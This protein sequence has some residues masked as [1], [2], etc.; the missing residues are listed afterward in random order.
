MFSFLGLCKNLLYAMFCKKYVIHLSGNLEYHFR[1]HNPIYNYLTIKLLIKSAGIVCL[2]KSSLQIALKYNNNSV[3]I[4]NFICN[5]KMQEISMIPKELHKKVYDFSYHGRITQD[6]GM[7]ELVKLVKNLH[8]YTFLIIGQGES[9]IKEKLRKFPNV[10]LLEPINNFLILTSIL[11]KSKVYIFPSKREG[12]PY[13]LLEAMALKLPI[14]SNCFVDAEDIVVENFG[15]LI[16]DMTKID[17]HLS[18]IKRLLDDEK[19]MQDMGAFNQHLVHTLFNEQN[20]ID[21]LESL[22][23]NI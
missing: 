18:K 16:V 1:M 11:V 15:G 23:K 8:E 4:P 13:S 21:K 5:L 9:S 10:T 2:N 3:L 22:L 14:I 12:F 19:Q 7:I 20:F 17:K 6:K